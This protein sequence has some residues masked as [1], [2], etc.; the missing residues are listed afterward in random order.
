ME[1]GKSLLYERTLNENSVA[2]FFFFLGILR[3][4][5]VVS[6]DKEVG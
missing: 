5:R 3:L 4:A 6:S 1:F 2:R